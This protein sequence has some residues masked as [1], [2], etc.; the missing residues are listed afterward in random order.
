MNKGRG[1]RLSAGAS[2]AGHGGS[3]GRGEIEPTTG[4]AYGNLYEPDGFGSAGG[5]TSSQSGI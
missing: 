2:G 4:A 1:R 3:G 5:G